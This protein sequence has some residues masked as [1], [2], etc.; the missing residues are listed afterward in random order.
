[1]T[2]TADVQ[3][4]EPG[5]LVTLYELDA[6]GIGAGSLKFHAHLQEGPIFWQGAE[7]SP[8]PVTADGFALTGDKPP[9][10]KLAVANI[11]RSITIL[12]ATFDDMVGARLIRRRTLAQYLDPQNFPDGV[13]P[14]ADPTEHLPDEVWFVERKSAE[15]VEAVEFELTSAMDF[16]GVML[17]RRQII[18][19]QCPFAYRG[20][21]CAYTG[22]AVAKSD[23]TPT[24][25]PLL[26][27][28]G[29]RLHSCE[30]RFGENQPLPFGGFPA[31]GLART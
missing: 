6:T 29:K 8:W 9:Q 5:K 2:T 22:G 14:T 3:G 25:D 7:Y 26:D 16:N 11:D 4:L 13:N 20:P 15:T 30:L 31:A 12:C 19:N 28:C 10:P 17:P 27:R 1:M 24:T 18:N 21:L 23:D